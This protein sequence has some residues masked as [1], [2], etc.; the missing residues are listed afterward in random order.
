MDADFA[1]GWSREVDDDADNVMYRTGMVIM[2]SGAAHCKRKLHLVHLKLSI[3]RCLP[4]ERS[5]ITNDNDGRNKLS[6][7]STH[8]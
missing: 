5:T 8:S 7:T 1:G 6:I 3:L 4:L 2:Y